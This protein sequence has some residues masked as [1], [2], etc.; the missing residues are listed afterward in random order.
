MKEY[1]IQ[2]DKLTKRFG[3]LVAVQQIS[4]DV[5]AGEIFAFLGPNGA[6]KT[7]TISM[8]TTLMRPTTGR[9]TVAGHDIVEA[10]DAVRKNI[11]IVFQERAL[12]KQLTAYENLEMHTVLYRVPK[13]ERKQRIDHALETVDLLDRAGDQVETFSGGM[14]RRL[15]IARALTHTPRVLFLDEPTLG[16]DPQT[17][18]RIWENLLELRQKTNLTIFLTTHYMEEAEFADRIAIIDGGEIIALDTPDVL[19]KQVSGDVV[20]LSTLNLHEDAAVIERQFGL[21]VTLYDGEIHLEVQDGASFIPQFVREYGGTV[22][23]IS[24]N[25][26]TLEDVFL[27]LTGRAIR[28]GA[29]E[30]GPINGHVNGHANEEDV[31]FDELHTT[32]PAERSG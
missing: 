32:T 13:A 20:N 30:N 23:K 25:R 19:K 1:A 29:R 4:F 26:P 27:K 31:G 17:R 22:Q 6:G 8:L 14:K 21:P 28:D 3:D 16:L 15:E 10:Q 11:G 12:D 24:L 5:P 2:V 18:N 7:T 9:A